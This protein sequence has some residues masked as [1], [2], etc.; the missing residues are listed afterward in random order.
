[1]CWSIHY[2]ISIREWLFNTGNVGVGKMGGGADLFFTKEG[3]GMIFSDPDVGGGD[4]FCMPHW[5]IFL[6][7][8]IK[9][10]FF[11]KNNWIWD[12]KY[13]LEEGWFWFTCLQREFVLHAWGGGSH[14]PNFLIP[15]SFKWP[16]PYQCSYWPAPLYFPPQRTYWLAD[17]STLSQFCVVINSC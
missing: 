7:N 12:I 6:I 1:M 10:L 9:R 16:L 14:Q 4:F 2:S 15:T 17:I 3:E 5:Q 8:V 13:E 11:M